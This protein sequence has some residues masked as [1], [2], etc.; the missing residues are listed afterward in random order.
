MYLKKQILAVCDTEA[1]YARRF[2]EYVSKKKDYPFEAAAFSSKE[3]LQAFC[4]EE[5]VD[6]LLV[7]EKVYEPS[8][9]EMVKG[10]V[11]ILREEEGEEEGKESI[12]KYQPC[13]DVLREMM[14][15]YAGRGPQAAARTARESSVRMI[16]IY[17]PVHRCMQTTF[18]ITLG[19]I[20]AKKHKV[21]Y[22]NFES[23]SGLDKRLDREFKTDMSDLMYYVSNAREVLFYKLKGMIDTIRNLDYIPPAFSYMDLARVLP[24]QWF[25][26]F[27]E[28]E[29]N[30]SYEYLILDLSENMQGLFDILQ[31]CEKVFTLVKEDRAAMA[32]LYQ[33]ERLLDRTDYGDILKRTRR[34]KLPL[35][36]HIPWEPEQLTYGELAEY[37]KRMVSEEFGGE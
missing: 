8:M 14:L 25:L 34:C 30:T 28:L 20:L 33:Y 9:G 22:L 13:E 36:R 26:L 23:F 24:E 7:S 10:D 12:Y 27:Q 15:H 29:K 31:M 19:E 17:T 35:I 16:G 6:V 3:K 18:A 11:L 21:L 32:K 5:R 1:D 2:C 4:R 37:V